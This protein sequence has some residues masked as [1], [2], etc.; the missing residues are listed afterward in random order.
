MS[1]FEALPDAFEPTPAD[2]DIA[3]TAA[4]QQKQYESVVFAGLG[5]PTLRL[6]VLLPSVKLIRSRQRDLNIRLNT[7]GGWL[8]EPELCRLE[9]VVSSGEVCFHA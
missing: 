5:E 2:V 9:H 8:C 4:F 6:G 1:A 7:N 3:V